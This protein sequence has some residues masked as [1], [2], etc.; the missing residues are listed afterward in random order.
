VST[1][2][3]AAAVFRDPGEAPAAVLSVLVHVALFSFLF[4]GVRWQSKLPDA[5]VVELWDRPAVEPPRAETPPKVEPK[6]EPPREVKPEPKP[7]PKVEPK[8]RKPDIAV[9]REKKITPKKVEPRLKLDRQQ[10]NKEQLAREMESIQREREKRE[11]LSKFQPLPAGPKIDAS[12]ANKIK[13]KIKSNIVLPPDIQGNPEAI[14]DVVQFPTGEVREVR[15]RKSSGHKAYDQAVERAIRKSSPL[16][17]PDRFDQFV[18][19][20]ELK[21]R[22]Q[23]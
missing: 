17:S 2:A 10:A 12:Y 8:P 19:N 21:F 15:L 13:A 7:E 4:F 3:A 18:P 14:F 6:P 5:V 1:A 11:V 16:P 9:E 20:L 22:P 23:E